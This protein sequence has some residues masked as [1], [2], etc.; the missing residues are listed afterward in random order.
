MPG[1][2]LSTL[3]RH[4]RGG[5]KPSDGCSDADLLARFARGHDDGAFELLVWRHGA[6]VLGACRRILA[7]SED[8]EDAFQ[9][10][11]L[12]LARKAGGIARGVAV[13]AWLHRVAVRVALRLARSRRAAAPLDV[14]PLAR[15]QPDPAERADGLAVLDEEINQLPERWR[16][17]V[18]LCYLE[19]LT[20]ADAGRQLGC[21]RGTVE[22]RLA[23]A[24]KRLRERLTRRGVTLPVG[25]LAVLTEQGVMAPEA[26]AQLVRGAAAFTRGGRG[27]A[28]IVGEPA[29]RLAKGV[30]I[31]WGVRTW[32]T[33]LAVV[34]AVAVT[35]GI[36]WANRA[37]PAEP[38]AQPTPERPVALADPP[39][40]APAAEPE[41]PGDPQDP[42]QP[43]PLAGQF[44]MPVPNGTLIGVTPDS[45][46]LILKSQATSGDNRDQVTLFDVASRKRP[47]VGSPNPIADAAVSPD[48]NLIATAEGTNGVKLRE[49]ATGKLVE[50]LWPTAGLPAQQVAFTPD[51]SRLIALCSRYDSDG[52]PGQIDAKTT[53]RYQV[54]VWDLA[55]KKELGHPAETVDGWRFFAPRTWFAAGGRFVLKSEVILKPDVKPQDFI[56]AGR[57]VTEG[58][59]LTLADPLTGTAG[60]PFEVRMPGHIP[61]LTMAETAVSPDGKSI[62]A[63]EPELPTAV[64]LLDTSTGKERL[65]LGKLSRP[66]KA[67]AFSPDG[68]LVAVAT[69]FGSGGR[70]PGGKFGPGGSQPGDGIAAPTEVVIWEATSGKEVVRLADKESSRNY[71]ALRFSPDGSYLVAQ[72]DSRRLTIWGHPPHPEPAKPGVAAGGAAVPDRFRALIRDLAADGVSDQRRV[73]CLFLAALG[74][75]PTDVES[76]TLTAQLARESDKSAGMRSI[77]AALTDTAEFKA[78]AAALQQLAR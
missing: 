21:P 24:R 48:G 17:A 25:V 60:K 34:A 75:L 19:G 30:L 15:P 37:R 58:Y 72:D 6:M 41:N 78:H 1:I 13:P 32:P 2:R 36:G 71:A 55:A 5:G 47:E 53:L 66:L 42:A 40:G 44:Q 33:V 62:L 14:E 43:W 65:R 74:R 70:P 9:G 39:A 76:R 27:A 7:H 49:V 45:R 64:M 29:V 69:G 56:G 77:L 8:A 31:M 61:A 10:T 38:P 46:A 57:A 3:V 28:E 52:G 22:S 12:I 50:A 11:F 20:A 35:A 59:R 51:G 23:A 63:H 67:V 73:E 16:R 4:L 26:V 68:K 54:S 18:V